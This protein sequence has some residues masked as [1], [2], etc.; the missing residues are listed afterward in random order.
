MKSKVQI[1]SIKKNTI[2]VKIKSSKQTI[3]VPLCVASIAIFMLCFS[4][5]GTSIKEVGSNM[6]YIYNPVNSLYND[7]SSVIFANAGLIDKESLD[8]VLPMSGASFELQTNGDIVFTVGNSIMLKASEGGVV[9][10]SGTTVDGIK[11]IKIQHSQ[12]VYSLIEN[13]DILGVK[14]GDTVKKGQ[15]VATAKIG[16]RVVFKLFLL[17]SQISNIKINQSKILWES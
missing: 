14:E 16:E 8:F 6:A 9:V 5:G 15:D 10:E 1:L 4:F 3:L 7:N 17:E 2:S 11:Y 13:V 12:D